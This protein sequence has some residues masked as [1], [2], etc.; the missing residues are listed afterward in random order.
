M[1]V[2]TSTTV[3]QFL[4]VAIYIRM[5]Y[6]NDINRSYSADVSQNTKNT[7]RLKQATEQSSESATE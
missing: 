1:H 6:T 5:N 2:T 3:I 4:H 7:L